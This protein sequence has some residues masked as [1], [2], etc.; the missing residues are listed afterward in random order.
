MPASHRTA[1]GAE[2]SPAQWTQQTQIALDA[3]DGAAN[4]VSWAAD[5]ELL[6]GSGS[7]IRTLRGFGYLLAPEDEVAADG[8]DA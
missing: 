4:S 7:L 8:S 2:T 3:A 5:A 6:V 1:A